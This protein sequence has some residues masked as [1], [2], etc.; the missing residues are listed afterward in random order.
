MLTRQAIFD[1]LLTLG[2]TRHAVNSPWLVSGSLRVAI[3]DAPRIKV[4]SSQGLVYVAL[5]ST[6]HLQEQLR[7][8]RGWA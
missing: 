5:L 6:T 4:L 3:L 7:T 2:F 1:Y 8:L